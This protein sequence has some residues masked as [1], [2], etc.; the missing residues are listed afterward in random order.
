MTITIKSNGH[1]RPL[2]TMEDLTQKEQA[3][4]DYVSPDDYYSPRFVRY[5]GQVVD[6]LEF[7]RPDRVYDY[8]RGW[9]GY[10]VNSFFSGILMRWA[11][12]GSDPDFEN[13]IMGRYYS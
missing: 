2:L 5:R 6:I 1:P 3:D 9:D 13:I 7:Q 8:F 11:S 4:F 12:D 10:H